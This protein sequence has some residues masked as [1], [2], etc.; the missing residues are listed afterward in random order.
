MVFTDLRPAADHHY[1]VILK[2]G[3][4][5]FLQ[6]GVTSDMVRN[7]LSTSEHLGARIFLW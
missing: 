7:T 3:R 1:L 5:L 6:Q 2:V 4:I